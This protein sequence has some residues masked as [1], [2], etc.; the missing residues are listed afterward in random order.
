M[1]LRKQKNRILQLFYDRFYGPI[2]WR[3]QED[4]AWDDMEAIAD[5]PAQERETIRFVVTNKSKLDHDF[6]IGDPATQ[7]AHRSEMAEAIRKGEGMAH[8]EDPN[9]MLV[10]AGQKRELIWKFTRAGKL[11]FDCNVPGHYEAGM[12]GT[13]AVR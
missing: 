1:Q 7:T 5:L 10:K 2:M 6:T 4:R 13:I 11:E 8:G 3:S 9:A 12:R